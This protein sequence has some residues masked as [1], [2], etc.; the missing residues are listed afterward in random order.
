MVMEISSLSYMRALPLIVIL[1]LTIT[2][3]KCADP[4]PLQ[5][6]CVA[7]TN[8]KF[9]LNGFPCINPS[10]V[11]ASQFKTSALGV[12]G[13]TSANPFGFNVTLTTA[14]NLPGFNTQGLAIARTD[15]AK[16]GLVPPHI[17]PRATEIAFVVK[18]KLLVG[19]V[20]TSNKLF[21]QILEAGDVFVF[22]RA[23]LHFL[24]NAGNSTALTISGLNSQNPGAQLVALAAFG[25][26]PEIP[27]AVL[28]KAFQISSEEVEKIRKNLIGG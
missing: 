2:Q 4:D 12:P 7:D 20:D 25:S 14:K 11:V 23:Q 18:G 9:F 27:P 5:D 28:E 16:G 15:F 24:F 1:A 13:N 17:H 19:F 10:T 6:F 8:S 21:T 26:K 22:P 3:V